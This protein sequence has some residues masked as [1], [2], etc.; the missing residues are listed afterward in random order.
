MKRIPSAVLSAPGDNTY[1]SHRGHSSF[2]A[3]HFLAGAGFLLMPR[4]E[5]LAG[6]T[7]TADF[8]SA[9]VVLGGDVSK[10]VALLSPS[11]QNAEQ[12]HG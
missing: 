6:Y 10:D 11:L 2:L 3:L 7:R 5:P 1:E 4:P 8:A 12:E 9:E